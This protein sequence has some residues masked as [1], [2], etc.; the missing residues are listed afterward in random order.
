MQIHEDINCERLEPPQQADRRG[1]F[2]E[3]KSKNNLNLNDFINKEIDEYKVNADIRDGKLL[4]LRNPF[5]TPH[6]ILLRN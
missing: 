6:G 5:N 1:P 2:F 3:C 4:T